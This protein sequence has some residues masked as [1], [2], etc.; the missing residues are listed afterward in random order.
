M[1]NYIDIVFGISMPLKIAWGVWVAW[2]AGQVAWYRRA[3]VVVLPRMLPTPKPVRK[4]QAA[5]A[6]PE[7]SEA[8][9]V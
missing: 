5:A 2:A 3:R 6:Q 9:P 1:G 7:L 8:A 4:Q